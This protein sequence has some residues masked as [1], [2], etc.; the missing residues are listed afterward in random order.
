MKDQR[1]KGRKKFPS[2]LFL[3]VNLERTCLRTRRGLDR[4]Y[5]NLHTSLARLIPG[6]NPSLI[7]GTISDPPKVTSV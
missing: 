6:L 7:P 1:N 2:F 3:L 5:E 4:W